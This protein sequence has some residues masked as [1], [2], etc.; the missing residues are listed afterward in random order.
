MTA[1]LAKLRRVRRDVNKLAARMDAL[2]QRTGK[3]AV[4]MFSV[5]RALDT[6]E[7]KRST[8]ATADRKALFFC[9]CDF[10]RISEGLLTGDLNAALAWVRANPK[11]EAAVAFLPPQTSHMPQHQDGRLTP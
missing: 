4:D 6:E 9:A 3:M 10:Q 7:T 5:V 11:Y 2:A 1:N 8:A